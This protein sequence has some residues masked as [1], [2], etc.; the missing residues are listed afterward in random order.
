MEKFSVGE[1]VLAKL[2]GIFH[3]AVVVKID[4]TSFEV[5]LSDT[6]QILVYTLDSKTGSESSTSHDIDKISIVKNIEPRK[7]ELSVGTRVCAQVSSKTEYQR[8]SIVEVPESTSSNVY[9]I[10]LNSKEGRDDNTSSKL[11]TTTIENIRLVK[12]IVAAKC[13]P[14]LIDMYGTAYDSAP[15]SMHPM[16]KRLNS[17]QSLDDNTTSVFEVPVDVA[18]YRRSKPVEQKTTSPTPTYGPMQALGSL[19]SYMDTPASA[20]TRMDSPQSVD[21]TPTFFSHSP[22]GGAP[23]PAAVAPPPPPLHTRVSHDQIP[24]PIIGLPQGA[25]LPPPPPP[26]PPPQQPLDY[27]PSMPRGPRIK[28]KDYKGAKKGEIIVTPE[29]V[30]K[31]FNGKQWRRLCG[32]EDC[33]KESQKCGLCSK[34]LNS[35]TPQPISMPR[36]MQGAVKRSLSTAIDPTESRK[37]DGSFDDSVGLKRRRVQSQSSAL[38]VSPLTD[39]FSE[40]GGGDESRKSVSGESTQDGRRSSTWEDFSESEQLAV[41]GLASLSS[42][43]NSTPF[44]PLTSPQMVSP[45]ANDVFHFGVRSSPPHLTATDFTAIGRLPVHHHHLSPP[46]QRPHTRKSPTTP[47]AAS[48]H[49]PYSAGYIGGAGGGQ[50]SYNQTSVF[51]MPAPVGYASSNLS[52]ASMNA[53]GKNLLSSPATVS[54]PSATPTQ[55]VRQQIS[56]F[57]ITFIYVYFY[58]IWGCAIIIGVDLTVLWLEGEKLALSGQRFQCA[59][60]AG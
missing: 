38:V 17:Q 30:K 15:T 2:K 39:V 32:V 48:Q 19:P 49:A 42:S 46:F 3:Q 50:Y 8:A 28:L 57:E 24:Q 22:H 16:D 55:K 33:W 35:P 14:G 41:F 44:S 5:K 45:M 11:A 26:P 60:I 58:C 9:K 59:I 29:G 52:S 40:N 10:S 12:G 54:S 37:S 56:V 27:Y 34:H 4:K 13:M 20:T 25:A 43:R 47:T 18:P 31:K 7:S 23:A 51:Q 36:R 6:N 1:T 53:G 21:Y